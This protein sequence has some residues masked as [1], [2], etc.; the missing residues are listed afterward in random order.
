[1]FLGFPSIF[2]AIGLSSA[3]LALTL[4][5]NWVVARAETYLLTWSVGLAI[6]VVA[7]L[8]YAGFDTYDPA[9]QLA[10]F[11]L[12]N[13]GFALIY[14]GSAEFCSGRP[15]WRMAAAACI[16]I[17]LPMTGA[18][19]LGYS[20]IGTMVDNA[21][22]ALLITMTARQYWRERHEAPLL[23]VA[24]AALYL[25]TAASFAACALVLLH[26]GQIV[27]TSRP[28]NW[29]E[30]F[31]SLMVIVGLT[32]IGALSLTINQIRTVNRHKSD[33]MTDPLTGL[34]NRRAL[35]GERPDP[36]P[37]GTAIVVMDLDHFK[38]INDRFGHPAGD[39]VLRGF[40]E[41]I[42]S[43]IRAQD[44]AARLG[45]E[46]FC[47]VLSAS[48]PKAVTAVAERI[49]AT[50]EAKVFPTAVGPIRATVSVGIAICTAAPESLQTLLARADKALYEAKAA[51]RNR[52][53][54][55]DIAIAA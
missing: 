17:V 50:L 21:G 28:A 10:A 6:I 15:H 23:M 19:G 54:S 46:E 32:G 41:V 2:V 14:A 55:A 3:A 13:I 40:A 47:I 8:L 52:V 25:V 22:A 43:N 16:A 51:G 27:L 53:H 9:L 29:A 5:A 12:M 35:F 4:L 44:I 20:G 45:G 30:D 42:F 18:F 49:R 48:S 38:A 33:A 24:N 39:R 34:M 11:V 7:V 1:M 26:N 31:N 36:T 37:S